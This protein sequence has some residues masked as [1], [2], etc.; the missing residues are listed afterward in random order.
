MIRS[1]IR[2]K[3]GGRLQ[4][5]RPR[6]SEVIERM[7]RLATAACIVTE[8]LV[9]VAKT[10]ITS[11]TIPA[12]VTLVEPRLGDLEFACGALRG[13]FAAIAITPAGKK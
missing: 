2:P 9:E 6:D 12:L 10:S 13:A 8:E 7:V 11:S 5:D 4:R 1:R 3:Q